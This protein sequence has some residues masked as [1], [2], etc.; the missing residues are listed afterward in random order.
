MDGDSPGHSPLEP[1]YGEGQTLYW[2]FVPRNKTFVAGRYTGSDTPVMLDACMD[3]W[4]QG[5][6]GL[7][8]FCLQDPRVLGV[9]SLQRHLSQLGLKCT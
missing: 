2:F 8:A 4:A 7:V 1:D 5:T 9:W 3:C 6:R